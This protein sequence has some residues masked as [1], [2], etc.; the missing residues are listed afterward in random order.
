MRI[1]GFADLQSG[2]MQR[3]TAD[4]MGKM[5]MWQCRYVTNEGMLLPTT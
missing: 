5:R 2:K 3:N 1:C 4:V